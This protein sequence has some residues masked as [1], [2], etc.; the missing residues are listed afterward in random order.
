MKLEQILN[1]EIKLPKIKT[2]LALFLGG[3]ACIAYTTLL[4]TKTTTAIFAIGGEELNP[5]TQTAINTFGQEN[6]LAAKLASATISCSA[7]Y[8]IGKY[9][10]HKNKLEQMKTSYFLFTL[11]ASASILGYA[12]IHNLN[13]LN[14][15]LTILK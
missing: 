4:D 7:M 12:A 5:I 13:E 3:V 14:Y 15:A 6:L 1:T 10:Q 2:D 9:H 11:Y 8:I